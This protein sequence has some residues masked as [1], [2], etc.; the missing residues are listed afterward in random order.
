VDSYKVN[1]YSEYILPVITLSVV[2]LV[3]IS[4][5]AL[6]KQIITSIESH[7]VTD[8][9]AYRD[10]YF[11]FHHAQIDRI[12][13]IWQNQDLANRQNAIAGT[14]TINDIPPSA[15]TTL[16]DIIDIG[17]NAPGITIREAMS[18]TSGPFCYI[19]I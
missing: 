18:T 14:H 16:D 6:G 2:I 3:E 13:W 7:R 15:N 8:N 12:W 5:L 9:K 19:Y 11:Y 17:Q 4:L 10:P 1:R